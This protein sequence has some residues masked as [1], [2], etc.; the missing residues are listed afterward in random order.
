[1][2]PKNY[3]P[4]GEEIPTGGASAEHTPGYHFED[5]LALYIRTPSEFAY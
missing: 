2:V 3:V 4:G 1:M 5:I